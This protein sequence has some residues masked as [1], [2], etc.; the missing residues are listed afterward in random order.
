MKKPLLFV[1]L[2]FLIQSSQSSFA[3][4]GMWTWVHGDSTQSPLGNYGVLGVADP[5]N[6]PPSVYEPVYWI[7][8]NDNLWV[9]G[10]FNANGELYQALW[11]YN[12]YTNLWTWMQGS[13]IPNQ[14][15]VY[16][17]Q[18]IPSPANTPGSRNCSVSWVDI[19]GNLWLMGGYTVGTVTLGDIW[20]FDPTT[21]EWTWMNGSTAL[22][23]TGTLTMG[24]PS[25]TDYPRAI[26]ETN[27]AWTDN[28]NQ[29]WVFGGI[30]SYY[31]DYYDQVI[32]Y[33][34]STNEWTW[35]SGIAVNSLPVW[36]TQ[37]VPAS[38]NNPG[39]RT[40]YARWQDNQGFFWFMNGSTVNGGTWDHNDVWRYNPVFA[41]W[42][43]MA[44]SQTNNAPGT[45]TSQ[46][47]SS[48]LNAPAGR[49]ED[50]SAYLD[51]HKRLWLFGGT[52]AV[53][54]DNFNDLW[55]FDQDSLKYKWVHG[56]NL[57]NQPGVYGQLNVPSPANIP[58]SR[59]G[60]ILF[61]D[62]L[63]NIYL[64][65]GI[66]RNPG[67]VTYNDVWKFTPDTSCIPCDIG[68]TVVASFTAPNQI[69]PG[70]CT[71]F[72]N[73]SANATSFI[74]SFPGGSPSVS[75]DA[76]PA[77]ICYNTPGSYDVTLIAIGPN[78]TD[79]ITITN[80]IEVYPNPAAQGIM[81]SGDT[82][83]AN[84][85]AVG[86][87]WFFNGNLISGATDYFYVANSSG[88]YNVVATDSNDCEVEAVIYDVVA[89]IQLAVPSSQVA[90]YPNPVINILYLMGSQHLENAEVII[91]NLLGEIVQTEKLV[92]PE[93]NVSGLSEGMYWLEILSGEKNMRVRF[94]KINN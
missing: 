92:A 50:K 45:Y 36:G 19:S 32:K 57:L 77:G 15:A 39:A 10:G 44:G 24:V 93:I 37:G 16:G 40:C 42:T 63:C 65:G 88:N 23:A 72:V 9:Y 12:P 18:G 85:G 34:I 21:L 87:Q 33:N 30:H 28:Q 68:L 43:W 86:Y 83:F 49:S 55:V 67:A 56:S 51:H 89:E 59:D 27:C 94:S 52:T 61:G 62:S 41:E 20:K 6:M 14:A 48:T 2:L 7:D 91:Y 22:A 46:C 79:T 78:G 80:Y 70:T 31:L 58:H 90:I 82:L 38:T 17:I 66:T 64:F 60:A 54:N 47:N 29:L 25:S 3:Q 76:S 5:A 69:C 35:L 13:N 71:D 84:Q 26:A 74:W 73:N 1:L 75:T 4:G 81:Q 11:K 53:V 8:S